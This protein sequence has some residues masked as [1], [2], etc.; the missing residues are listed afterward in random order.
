MRFFYHLY[1]AGDGGDGGSLC[2]CCMNNNDALT[3]VVTG[4]FAL[5]VNTYEIKPP[6]IIDLEGDNSD[7]GCNTMQIVP[8]ATRQVT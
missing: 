5:G 3:N 7:Y 1:N 2:D 4:D 6:L 8:D